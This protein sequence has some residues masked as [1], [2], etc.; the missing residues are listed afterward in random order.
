MQVQHL[1]IMEEN[2]Y[3]FRFGSEKKQQQKTTK[4]GIDSTVLELAELHITL[5]MPKFEL[6]HLNLGWDNSFII[7][8]KLTFS[9][10]PQPLIGIKGQEGGESRKGRLLKRS[11]RV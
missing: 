10:A 4:I 9:P 3:L 11:K 6:P 8:V 5:T 1:T 2:K 7:L